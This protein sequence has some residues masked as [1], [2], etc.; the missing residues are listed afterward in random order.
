MDKHFLLGL[1]KVRLAV[2]QELIG[3]KDYWGS[4]WKICT[5]PPLSQNSI[6]YLK[7]IN[8]LT[9]YKTCFNATISKNLEYVTERK[10]NLSVKWPSVINRQT[11]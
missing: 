10:V 2:L 4:R 5:A 1:D 6:F 11:I 9:F 8:T 3:S 7:I